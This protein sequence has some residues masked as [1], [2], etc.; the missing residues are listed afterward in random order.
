MTAAVQ[1]EG[2]RRGA[3]LAALFA[4]YPEVAAIA[5][6]GSQS[7]G[8]ADAK[9]D[10]DLYVYLDGALP[11]GAQTAV[12]ERAGGATQAQLELPYWGG[13][14]LWIDAP[15]GLMV[16]AIYFGTDWMAEQVSRVL[17]AHVASMG[18]TTCFCRT[19]QQSRVLYDPRGWLA[20]LQA[21]TAQP[22]PEALRRN[23]VAYNQPL[24]RA[25]MTSYLYQ[26][27]RAVARDDAVSVNHRV[28]GLLA[29]Y[30]DIVFAVNRVLH[31]GEKRLLVLAQRECQLL[32]A[33]MATDVLAVLAAA[34][35]LDA[36]LLDQLNRLID[37]LDD[38]LRLAGVELPAAE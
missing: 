14:N 1:L 10:I 5:L 31:P 9:S 16:D 20:A 21:R 2:S 8:A 35:T 38:M 18:Y 17:D 7:S 13:A 4:A 24:L 23:I 33:D 30:F 19:I 3:E 37:R 29:S 11:E 6:G 26:I 12:I 25:M 27:E 15:T 22:Y 34:G 32:P 36:A 28:A